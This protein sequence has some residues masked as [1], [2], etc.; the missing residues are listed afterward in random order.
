VGKEGD[1]E[2]GGVRGGRLMRRR[3]RGGDGEVVCYEDESC[4]LL[5]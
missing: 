1:V 3:R 4:L 5:V 2:R